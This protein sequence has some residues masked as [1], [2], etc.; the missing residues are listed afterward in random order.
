LAKRVSEHIRHGALAPGDRIGTK[1]DLARQYGVSAGTVNSAVRLLEAA[2]MAA[3]KPGIRGGVFVSRPR[4]R[5]QV[6]RIQLTLRDSGNLA[7]AEDSYRSR[8][9]LEV[10]LARL[11]ARFR[12]DED[13][14]S[15]QLCRRRLEESYGRDVAGYMHANWELHDCVARA[16][17]NETLL[18]VYRAVKDVVVADVDRISDQQA[19]PKRDGSN[20]RQHLRLADCVIAGDVEAATVTA[21]EHA[22]RILK[23]LGGQRLTSDMA[24]GKASDDT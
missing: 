7:L 23:H 13:I 2:G 4:T 8:V 17:H 3:A 6:G 21:E 22:D 19:A 15:L 16:A 11:A 18:S 14:T 9:L 12:T 24:A 5:V 20:L 1:S 10:L